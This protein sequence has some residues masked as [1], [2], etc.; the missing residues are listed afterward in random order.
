MRITD[1]THA[2]LCLWALVAVGSLAALP[3]VDGPDRFH[4]TLAA[5]G[6][7]VLALADGGAR[8][9]CGS[10]P[11]RLLLLRGE[12]VSLALASVDD[13]EAVPGIG[14]AR[15]RAIVFDREHNGRFSSVADLARVSGIGALTVE[16][17]RPYLAAR[18]PDCPASRRIGDVGGV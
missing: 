10:L 6:N 2:R 12:R 18:A 3:G 7:C 13:L 5:D 4:E 1:T 9:P 8:C 11:A 15:A 16:R 17:L 14:P